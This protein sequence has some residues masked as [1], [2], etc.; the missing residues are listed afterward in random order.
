[1][2]LSVCLALADPPSVAVARSAFARDRVDEVR[3]GALQPEDFPSG[4]DVLVFGREFADG[5]PPHTFMT[6][7]R[8]DPPLAL[9]GLLPHDAA[10]VP[11]AY[12]L[13]RH[14]VHA[15]AIVNERMNGARLR[16]VTE[17]AY[18]ACS[19]GAVAE[20]L[21][22][23]VGSIARRALVTAIRW[24]DECLTAAGLAS[25][26]G[27]SLLALRRRLREAGLPS[28]RRLLAWCRLLHAARLLES[29]RASTERVGHVVGYASGPA[30]R[31]ACRGMLHVQPHDLAGMGGFR[32]VLER[33]RQELLRQEGNG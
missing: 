19:M 26:C 7:R 5:A 15:V 1:M 6:L 2:G 10:C 17:A 29:T 12:H 22:T 30:F 9:V 8:A 24:T 18:V 14:G 27:V 23:R 28:P 4:T 3:P 20:A 16:A 21:P 11:L 31:N 32:F 33:M 13:G 25:E